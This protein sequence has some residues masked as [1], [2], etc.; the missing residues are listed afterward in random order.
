MKKK[1]TVFMAVLIA[2]V[3][4]A[5]GVSM[6]SGDMMSGNS[7]SSGSSMMPTGPITGTPA[8]A[9]L[10]TG[11]GTSSPEYTPWQQG[12]IQGIG[13]GLFMGRVLTLASQQ[14]NVTGFNAE[15][16]R[17]NSW[18]QQNIGNDPKLLMQ[19]MPETNA[20]MPG[21]MPASPSY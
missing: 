8:E 5:M 2:L 7:M 20:G 11:T 10:A 17:F 6:S 9:G 13:L 15:V 3:L 21:N 4:P 1:I 16:D 18:I 19:K 14:N 12:V